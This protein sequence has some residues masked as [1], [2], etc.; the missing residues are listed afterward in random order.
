[1][2]YTGE[3]SGQ[4]ASL[5][6]HFQP[7]S[8]AHRP[9]PQPP[10][11]RPADGG[12]FPALVLH[13]PRAPDTLTTAS[14]IRPAFQAGWAAAPP[15]MQDHPEA[16]NH[17]ELVDRVLP[18]PPP[19]ESTKPQTKR[20]DE[21]LTNPAVMPAGDSIS[22]SPS[23]AAAAEE[24]PP[25]PISKAAES[26]LSTSF[27]R[28]DISPTRSPT[29][30]LH[31]SLAQ[32]L[33]SSP[34]A[35]A[36]PP[37]D[38]KPLPTP[39]DVLVK[40][41]TAHANANSRQHAAL[42]ALPPHPESGRLHPGYNSAGGGVGGGKSHHHNRSMSGSSILDV[43]E[44]QSEDT[45]GEIRSIMVPYSP[46]LPSQSDTSQEKIQSSED[47]SSNEKQPLSP[48]P[49]RTSSL[50]NLMTVD[51]PPATSPRSPVGEKPMP[52]SPLSRRFS[53]TLDPRSP[54]DP[55]PPP[56]APDPEPPLPFDFHRFLEQLRHRTADPVAK[57]LRSFLGE[58]GKRQWE[59]HDQVRFISD[60]LEFIHGKMA[61]CEVWREVSDAEFDN[62]KEGMEKLVMNRLYT[63]TFSP[64]IPPPASTMDKRG[65]RRSNPNAPGRTGQHQEDVERDEILT[66]K[67]GIYGWVREEH[68]DIK[69]VGEQGRKFLTLA[70]KEILKINNYRAPRDKVICVL[71][72]CKVIFGLLRNSNTSQSADNFVPL[73]I[74]VVL[75]S[76]PDHL[77]SNIQYILRFRNPDKLNGEAGYYLSSLSGAIQF[78][79][80]LDRNSLTIGDEEFET[81]VEEAVKKIAEKKDPVSP[82]LGAT[83]RGS[84]SEAVDPSRR[85]SASAASGEINA[86][87]RRSLDSRAVD[88]AGPGVV[89][90]EKAA[91]AGL[92]QT[93]QRPLSTIGR[94]FGD[95]SSS[96][97]QRST[98]PQ[99]QLKPA[100]A[101]GPVTTPLP[102]NTPRTSPGPHESEPAAQQPQA[103]ANG[104]PG[105]R[106]LQPTAATPFDAA[107][108]A[109]RQASAETAEAMRIQ[110]AEHENVVG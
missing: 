49:P 82:V 108:S 34:P 96:Q 73:L 81:N 43:E 93:L 30:P 74:Y 109:A 103:P 57:Y 23:A 95:D 106:Y 87:R 17:V 60:F 11:S 86:D 18:P 98:T 63:Q 1:M 80:G 25:A 46:K 64:A 41:E 94:I 88:H 92:L 51:R 4:P 83:P 35:P 76:N 59:V 79:E 107:E 105:A 62:A 37:K 58:F 55:T 69:P 32:E 10:R 47:P 26:H 53:T 15:A 9:Q 70:S 66:Q 13:T 45:K 85:P 39:E 36:P 48:I 102:G 99:P 104:F 78:I 61:M 14:R 16:A 91:V 97:T 100:N 89:E 42:P 75:R 72:C 44:E 101:D 21:S 5:S 77:V 90:E 50:E 29:R 6:L 7:A 20:W 56:P 40:A 38:D 68:L 33:P 31:E 3:P 65:K 84:V 67:V 52:P 54:A 28:L 110:R 22:T 12:S 19:P 24:T 71:N 27:A 2:S 8:Q